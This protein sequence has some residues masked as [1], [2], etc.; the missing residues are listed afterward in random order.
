[1][2]IVSLLPSATEIVCALGA[3]PSLVGVSHECDH[4]SEARGLPA[5]TR[6]KLDARASSAAIDRSVRTLVEQGLGVYEIDV[7]RLKELRPDVIVTQN[8]CDVCAVSY[9]DV[10]TAARRVLGEGV[11][12]VSLAPQRLSD[13]W[14]D[15]ERVAVALDRVAAG[16]ALVGHARERLAALTARVRER[17]RP[18]VACIEW[19][20]PLMM[21]ANW[22]PDLVDVAGGSYPFARA[23]AQST[24]ADWD[25]VA[26][27]RPDVVVLMPCGFTIAQTRRELADV[28]ARP[29]WRRLPAVAAGRAWIVD[30]NGY[31]NR[32]GPRL[33]ESAEILAGLLHP[34]LGVDSTLH[35]AVA[36]TL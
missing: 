1:M 35:D 2:R 32:P 17:G 24:R 34:A 33:V 18:T 29:Q 30:G 5:V 8:Q 31:F 11:T 36:A 14:D 16:R 9:V 6:A 19:L 4:P 23:G 27:A 3:G 10:E 25:V 22:T 28:R 13:V 15:V 20:D 21:A 26:E 7:A 12:I